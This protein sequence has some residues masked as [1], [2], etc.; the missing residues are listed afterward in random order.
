[1]RKFV[2]GVMGP[3]ENATKEDKK[4][5]FELGELILVSLVNSPQ[6]AIKKA[7]SLL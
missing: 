7:E 4:N 3:G 5:A 2:I 6:E 1:M